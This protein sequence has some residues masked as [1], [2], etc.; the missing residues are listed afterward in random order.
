MKKNIFY[1]TLVVSLIWCACNK[2]EVNL[3]QPKKDDKGKAYFENKDELVTWVN[4]SENTNRTKKLGEFEFTLKRLS[5]DM[6]ALQEVQGN[7][8]DAKAY[9][10][11][12]SHY[13][14]LTYY[15]LNISNPNYHRELLKYNLSGPDEYTDRVA[16][17][18]FQINRDLYMTNGHDTVPCAIHEFERTF[19][20][21]SGL[22]FV[23]AFPLIDLEKEHTVVL[24]DQLF[25]NG[26]VKFSFSKN[27]NDLP[28]FKIK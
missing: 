11:A 17:C 23:I 10:E 8:T 20:I 9:E 22:N 5:P 28:Y 7:T 15:K 26:I 19:N 14:G 3:P 13:T 27:G 18:S 2:S 12:K 4:T 6:M 1:I 16:Y 24:Q 21:E 25:H